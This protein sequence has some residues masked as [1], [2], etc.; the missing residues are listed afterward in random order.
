MKISGYELF[1]RVSGHRETRTNKVTIGIVPL[2]RNLKD[3]SSFEG[4]T[5]TRTFGM[6]L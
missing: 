2:W 4:T 3:N 5:S 6:Q 1:L